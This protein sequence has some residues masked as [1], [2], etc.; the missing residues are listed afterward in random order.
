MA[1]RD[2]GITPD[3]VALLTKLQDAGGCTDSAALRGS[4]VIALL[5]EGL[6]FME[7]GAAC[8]SGTGKELL[9]RRSGPK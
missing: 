9:R 1:S 2:S 6:A 4:D 3:Q 7:N 8:I 5:R